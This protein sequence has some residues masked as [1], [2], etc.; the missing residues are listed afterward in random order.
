L[1]YASIDFCLWGKIDRA[2][3]TRSASNDAPVTYEI[4]V[5]AVA[6]KQLVNVLLNLHLKNIRV[7]WEPLSSPT[8]PQFSSSFFFS[9]INARFIF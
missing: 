6:K 1:W 5:K 3:G 4:P 8:I 7:R 2:V 9:F